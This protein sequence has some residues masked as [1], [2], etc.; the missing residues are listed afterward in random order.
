[1]V[2]QRL[3]AA[4]EQPQNVVGSR[5]YD[6]TRDQR[7]PDAQAELL[8]AVAQ[9]AAAQALESIE[10]EMAAIEQWNRQQIHQAD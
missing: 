9:R 10:Q 7:D 3:T 8:D 4:A 1:M 5:E 6:Q 2:D